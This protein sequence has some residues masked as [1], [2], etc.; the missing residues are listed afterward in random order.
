MEYGAILQELAPC[1]IDCSR[2]AACEKGEIK[3]LSVM[4]DNSLAS[5]EKVAEKMARFVPAL[6]GYPQ[7]KEVLEFFARAGCPGC[8]A[9][10]GQNPHCAA[11]NCFREKGVDF[12]FQCGE[13]PCSKNDYDHQL[14][15]KWLQSNNRMK[16]AGV[17]KFYL[18]QRAR[19]R[20]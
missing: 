14:A 7:F 17:E 6:A 16:E 12:C 11:R 5:F 10:G 20:Y 4:L 15:E 18:E 19:P 9:G 1:G 2:C 8:R 3:R 13:F